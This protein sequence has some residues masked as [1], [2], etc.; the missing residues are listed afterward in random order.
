MSFEAMFFDLDDTLYPSTSGIWEAIGERMDTFITRSL[1]ISPDEVRKLRNDLFHEYGTTL[2]G[3]R[4]LYNIDEREFLD[5]VHDIPLDQFLQESPPLF[6]TLSIYP[7]RKIIFTNAS[8]E[9]AIRVLST[10]GITRFFSEVIDVLQISPYCKPLPE[11]FQKAI[12][13]SGIQNPGD[14]VVIDDSPRN[15]QTARELGFFT[16][17]VGTEIRCPHADAAIISILDLPEV[18]PATLSASSG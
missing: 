8:Q 2:R 13:I 10:L 17:Q 16:I 5:F 9:H 6:D 7:S 1:G 18:I 14:C 15:L 4:A 3:L 11:A 12:E